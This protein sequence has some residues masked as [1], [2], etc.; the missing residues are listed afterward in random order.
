ME[1]GQRR[2][3]GR[4]PN[5]PMAWAAWTTE[6]RVVQELMVMHSH[7]E[8]EAVG[9]EDSNPAERRRRVRR[10]WYAGE[11][12][13]LCPRSSRNSRWSFDMC[14]FFFSEFYVSLIFMVSDAWIQSNSTEGAID[15]LA[16]W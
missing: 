3:C 16:I 5:A 11:F 1:K 10:Y 8:A 13:L 12:M 7:V 2:M 4:V 15:N 9:R 6:R 14:R